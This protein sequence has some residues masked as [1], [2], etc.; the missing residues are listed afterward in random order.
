MC[1]A[2]GD[3]HEEDSCGR[4]RKELEDKEDAEG[5]QKKKLKQMGM[6]RH[7]SNASEGFRYVHEKMEMQQI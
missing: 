3:N 1:I 4:R 6:R 5:V 7:Q 2:Y